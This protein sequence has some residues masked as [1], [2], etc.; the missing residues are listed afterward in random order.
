MR[1]LILC[2][3]FT[4]STLLRDVLRLCGMVD[5]NAEFGYEDW[6]INRVGV[7]LMGGYDKDHVE[8][9][10]HILRDYDSKSE[11]AHGI[12]VTH[13]LQGPCWKHLGPI[14]E[15]EWPDAKYV[16]SIRHPA[17][18]VKAM[19]AV[20]EKNG[21]HEGD[22]T[23]QTVV[24]SWM[25]TAGATFHLLGKKKATLVVYPDDYQS[26]KI[27]SIVSDL[28]LRWSTEAEGLFDL[29]KATQ[30]TEDEIRSFSYNYPEAV[31]LYE[32]ILRLRPTSDA[33]E[34]LQRRY[35]GDDPFPEPTETKTELHKRTKESKRSK[36][37]D[38]K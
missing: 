27:K 18:I 15:E 14:F 23:D 31:K 38:K 16:I 24:D 32:D 19:R 35:I 11:G 30:L 3:W 13:A 2:H 20:I 34:T 29:P 6:N 10:H 4:G 22:M 12:K 37:R 36:R 7:E 17:L 5:C 25:S 21:P 28:G 1:F 26:G 8:G 9:V 33:V